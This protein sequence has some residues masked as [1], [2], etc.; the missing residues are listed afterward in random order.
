MINTTF[1]DLEN[2]CSQIMICACCLRVSEMLD[3]RDICAD[4]A[5]EDFDSRAE[6][7]EFLPMGEEL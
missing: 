7:D 1:A 5:I 6:S 2:E 3:Y 4:C